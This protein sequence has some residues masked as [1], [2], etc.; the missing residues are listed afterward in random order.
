M[1]I[2]N[3]IEITE[4]FKIMQLKNSEKNTKA[5]SYF[6]KQKNSCEGERKNEKTYNTGMKKMNQHGKHHCPYERKQ[7]QLLSHG[8]FLFANVAQSGRIIFVRH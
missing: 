8:N 4:V 3:R 5:C 1:L 6:N 2:V 7:Q